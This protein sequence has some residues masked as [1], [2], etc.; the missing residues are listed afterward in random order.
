MI[1]CQGT[2][3]TSSV[4]LKFFDCLDPPVSEEELLLQQMAGYPG[5]MMPQHYSQME[6]GA[7]QMMQN[8]SL[9]HPG[10]QRGYMQPGLAG[11]MGLQGVPYGY[12]PGAHSMPQAI[13]HQGMQVSLSD[14]QLGLL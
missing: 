11:S 2:G 14:P 1:S 4:G 5:M 13:P 9:V 3:T 12:I 7:L 6:A 10:E 8:M